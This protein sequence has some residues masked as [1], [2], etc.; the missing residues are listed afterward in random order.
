VKELEK[1]GIGRP[2]TYATIISTIQ[3][4]GYVTLEQRRFTATELGEI[5]TDRLVEHFG[6]L[7]NTDFTARMENDLDSVENGDRMWD[8]VVSRFH[9]LF[10]KDL[11][12]AETAM[13]SI[14]ANPD[15]SDIKCD[16]CGSPMAIL[17][18]KRGKFLGCSRYPECRNTMP[19][20]G[21][22][23][24][25]EV[26]ETDYRCP[27]CES[28][29]VIRDGRRG[30]FLAC[31]AFPKCR[32][33]ASVDEEGRIVQPKRTGIDCDKCGSE[34]V[35]KSSRRGP[36]LACSG[37]PKCRNARPLPEELRERPRE[38]DELCDKCGAPMVIKASRWG[39]EFLA[40]SAYPQCRNARDLPQQEEPAD[41]G[42]AANDSV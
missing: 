18:N 38:T 8:D 21:P 26:I 40:R 39:K 19:V 36:F 11:E 31:T 32:S 30:R 15:L 25:S 42:R 10:A 20:D 17:F 7:I 23:E 2:S 5:V 1:K 37:F 3:D 9:A 35:V 4:R 12:R 6:D 24:K 16:K 28:P 27:K 29:M 33:T 22:R 34:M 41:A 14:K 13:K